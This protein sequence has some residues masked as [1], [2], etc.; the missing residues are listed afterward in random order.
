MFL[1]LYKNFKLKV[2][3]ELNNM[4]TILIMLLIFCTVKENMEREEMLYFHF[5]NADYNLK[6]LSRNI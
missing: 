3:E 6:E 4:H 1:C 5:V 2:R